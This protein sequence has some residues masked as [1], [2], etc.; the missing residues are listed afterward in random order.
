LNNLKIVKKYRRKINN[1][2]YKI[3][4]M[5]KRQL[6]FMIL[7]KF[8]SKI[9]PIAIKMTN[10]LKMMKKLIINKIKQILTIKN[11]RMKN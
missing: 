1:P 6:I 4:S 7:V 9:F 2:M 5:N 10:L 8:K 11:S 3:I